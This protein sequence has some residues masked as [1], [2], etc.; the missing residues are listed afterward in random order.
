LK[1]GGKIFSEK[2]IAKTCLPWRNT[3]KIAASSFCVYLF[4]LESLAAKSEGFLFYSLK[5][6]KKAAL[7]GLN[8]KNIPTR[9]IK[10]PHDS[11][12]VAGRREL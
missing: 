9:L 2:N 8:R 10:Q 5:Q 6:S 7:S 11:L 4:G 3:L 12:N 1:G